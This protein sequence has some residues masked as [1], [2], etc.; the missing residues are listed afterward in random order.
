[1]KRIPDKTSEAY[2]KLLIK[3][4]S[5]N[6]DMKDLGVAREAGSDINTEQADPG[7]YVMPY[8]D[9]EFN[10]DITGIINK[11][12]AEV[13]GSLP[14]V[15]EVLPEAYRNPELPPERPPRSDEGQSDT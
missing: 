14:H 7:R 2:R 8:R 12:R 6:I 15:K 4:T 3:D 11:S 9:A 5:D 13:D 1:M 10:E